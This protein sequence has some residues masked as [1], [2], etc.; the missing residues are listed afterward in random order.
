MNQDR[1]L[2][3]LAEGVFK[4]FVTK[5][6]RIEILRINQGAQNRVRMEFPVRK[7]WNIPKLIYIRALGSK[8]YSVS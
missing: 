3:L 4:V 6:K 5:I 1:T 2:L 7:K 8:H